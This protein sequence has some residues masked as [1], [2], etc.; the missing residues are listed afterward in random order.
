MLTNNAERII[1][2]HSNHSICA[3]NIPKIKTKYFRGLKK[4]VCRS[5]AFV[6]SYDG[7]YV[8]GGDWNEIAFVNVGKDGILWAVKC[9]MPASVLWGNVL[10]GL[11]YITKYHVLSMLTHV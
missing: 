3:K 9:D 6:K 11:G 7:P 10:M 4:K 2:T 8:I 1:G 5:V